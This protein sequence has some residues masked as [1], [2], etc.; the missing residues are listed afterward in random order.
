MILNQFDK[1][2]DIIIEQDNLKLKPTRLLGEIPDKKLN[3]FLACL[4]AAIVGGLSPANGVMMGNAM[5]GL[6]SK[7]ETVRYDKG[8]KYALLFLLVAFLQGLGNT[9]MNWQFMVMGASLMRTYRKKI[10]TLEYLLKVN[11]F[12]GRTYNDLTQ[13]LVLPWTLKDYLDI[14]NKN[15]FRDFSL[16]MSV[17][18][19]ESLEIIKRYYEMDNDENRSHFKCHYSNS[20]YVTLY[21]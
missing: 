5:N 21:L 20:S 3:M 14:Y 19:K 11:K 1:D 9:L 17:Q 12:S 13:Y 4:G 15:Y 7:Y 8:L 10:S 18:E 16:P 6:N 2:E